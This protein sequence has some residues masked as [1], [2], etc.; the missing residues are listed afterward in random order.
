[1]PP[2]IVYNILIIKYLFLSQ[3]RLNSIISSKIEFKFTKELEFSS[4]KHLNMVVM[5][6][7][8]YKRIEV[9]LSETKSIH[10]V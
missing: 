7:G 3:L 10:L 6:F 5:Q 8:Y 1:M 9:Y 2:E 4:Q